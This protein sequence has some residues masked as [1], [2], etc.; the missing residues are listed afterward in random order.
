VW[1]SDRGICI[2]RHYIE[3]F[4]EEHQDDVQG[5]VLEVHDSIYTRRYGGLRVRRADVI[6]IDPTNPHATIIADLR[7]ATAIPPAAYDCI[8]LTQTLHVI[9][10]MRAVA[11]E[12]RRILRPGGVLLAS[13][14]CISRVDDEGGLD[15]DFW[16]LSASAVRQLFGE[17]FSP[18]CLDVHAHGN[19]L[20]SIAFLY[21]LAAHELTSAE[22]EHFDSAHP[23]DVTLRAVAPR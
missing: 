17:V 13:F 5:D 16:R 3:R 8:I 18:E 14:P 11:A 23:L 2:D 10:Q 22:L 1:G 19:L 4:L 7:D 9:Y 20:V 21:G 6:D 15:G 12:C